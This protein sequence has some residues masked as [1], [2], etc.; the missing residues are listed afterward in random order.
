MS[1]AHGWRTNIERKSVRPKKALVRPAPPRPPPATAAVPL[2]A[3]L[4]LNAGSETYL[5]WKWK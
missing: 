3:M 1:V 4:P 2:T 5:R